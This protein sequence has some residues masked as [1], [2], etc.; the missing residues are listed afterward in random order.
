MP[1]RIKRYSSH[2]KPRFPS[3]KAST[4]RL[5]RDGDKKAVIDNSSHF[6]T[7]YKLLQRAN[8]P[9]SSTSN[10]KQARMLF[11]EVHRTPKQPHS[12][13]QSLKS[14]L[15]KKKIC[16]P[17]IAG[18]I[19]SLCHYNEA[20]NFSRSTLSLH[21]YSPLSFITFEPLIFPSQF[22]AVVTLAFKSQISTIHLGCCQTWLR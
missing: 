19:P 2:R 17:A 14:A 12:V 3:H 7:S 1:G 13:Q 5:S 6:S 20:L 15:E 8:C 4:D 11:P 16:I 18:Q 9:M 22:V 21:S 10:S